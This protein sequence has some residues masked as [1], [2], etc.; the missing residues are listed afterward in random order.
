MTYE[1]QVTPRSW[2]P[3]GE[4]ELT[5][6]GKPT[7]VWS[8]IVGES[9]RVRVVHQGQNRDY[10]VFR[11]AS[12]PSPHRVDPPCRRY[13]TCGGCPLMHLDRDGQHGARQRL[14]RDALAAEGLD[15]VPVGSVV[16][17]PDGEEEFRW[18]VKLGVGF[19]DHGHLRVGAWGRNTRSIV[20]IP[21][22][23]VAADPLRA[24]MHA[25]AHHVRELGL[26]PYDPI[27]DRGVLRAIVVRGSRTH[28]DLLVTLVAGR[29]VRKLTEL[30]ERIAAQVSTVSG[31]VLHLNDDEGNAIYQREEDGE[32]GSTVLLGRPWIEET[33]A[34]VDYRIGPG[35]F[36]QT[37][38][39]M[40]EVLYQR[41]LDD[42]GLGPGV[43]VVD[44][45]AGVGGFALAA[46]RRTGFA[47]GVESVAGA[48]RAAREAAKR[49]DITAEFVSGE[50][51]DVLPGIAR[52]LRG[53]AP[54]VTVNPARRGLEE[55]VAEAIAA[56]G[57]R[58]MAYISCNPRAMARDLRDL[59]ERGLRIGSIALY[60]M[61]P[62]TA[63]VE[64]VALLE[65]S[66]D[67]VP[68]RRAPRRRAVGKARRRSDDA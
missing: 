34:G 4:A 57:P 21:E 66:A 11:E 18:V 45:Y 39:G 38:P 67:D 33:L 56:L 6:R 48:V 9:A 43:P 54:V 27:E 29:R 28:G 1:V 32:I 50:V 13:H 19:S 62:H 15:D 65:G 58:R 55:G 8:G 14:V 22:C 60:D 41:T 7:L 12:P 68:T 35:D 36:F 64:A 52:R 10:A 2:S 3:R 42:L 59:S 46:A 31:V 24:S 23:L 20:P 61:F 47:I 49:N 5:V 53:T 40:A 44:L 26:G 25:I 17:S 16:P 63:H 51:V 37:N 30:A